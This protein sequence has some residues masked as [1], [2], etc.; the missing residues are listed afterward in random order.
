MPYGRP[1]KTTPRTIGSDEAKECSP[2]PQ[3][4]QHCVSYGD[5]PKENAATRR[6]PTPTPEGP[7]RSGE[8]RRNRTGERDQEP[9]KKRRQ[10]APRGAGSRR[11]H[12]WG[13]ISPLDRTLYEDHPENLFFL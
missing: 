7:T 13:A 3:P 12:D 2:N 5:Y 1:S 10:Y 6:R 4:T 9:P 11:K 8:E